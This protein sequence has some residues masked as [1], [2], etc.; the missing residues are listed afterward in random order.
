MHEVWGTCG[1][2]V[3]GSRLSHICICHL[4]VACFLWIAPM[5]R[6]CQVRLCAVSVLLHLQPLVVL[7]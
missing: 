7:Q 1:L 5:T 3:M 4:V 6:W 2:A